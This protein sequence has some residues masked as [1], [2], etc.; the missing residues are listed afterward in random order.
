MKLKFGLALMLVVSG[1][2]SANAQGGFRRSVEERVQIVHAKMDSAF[3]LDADKQVK[4]DTV[5]ANYYRQQNKLREELSSGGDRPD[6]QVMREK[7]QPMIEARDKELKTL[8]TEEQFRKWKEE[9][10]PAMMPR[11]RDRQ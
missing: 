8:L 4:V 6:F 2:I 5:F 9:I 10:E 11:R 7:M 3:K 1:F